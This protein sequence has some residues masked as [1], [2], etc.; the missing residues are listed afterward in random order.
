M[1]CFLP[2][3]KTLEKLANR[4]KVSITKPHACDSCHLCTSA[5]HAY[6]QAGI[7]CADALTHTHRPSHSHWRTRTCT[8]LQTLAHSHA[9]PLTHTHIHTHTHILLKITL[10]QATDMCT[11]T[12]TRTSCRCV[13]T[14][15][16][17]HKHALTHTHKHSLTLSFS[18]S[19]V[20]TGMHSC[21]KFKDAFLQQ[22]YITQPAAGAKHWPNFCRLLL[23]CNFCCCRIH[24]LST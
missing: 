9:H 14:R 4:W 6:R 7:H 11:C 23:G 8:H 1:L 18:L 5:V 15:M 12:H 22:S 10:A 13:H 20:S 2:S 16:Y 24:A 19:Q 21:K 17:T 3:Y